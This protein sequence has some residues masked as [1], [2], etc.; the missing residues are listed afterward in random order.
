MEELNNYIKKL[1][2]L[3]EITPLIASQ[4]Q[5]YAYINHYTYEQMQLTLRYFYEVKGNDVKNSKGIGIIPFVF[6][7][8]RF[9]YEQVDKANISNRKND[10]KEVIHT[11]TIKKPV[12][13]KKTKKLKY[14]DRLE[15]ED[16]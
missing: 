14:I 16:R 13:R 9:Y 1:F 10:F 4:I 11:V 7:D 15:E 6:D 2:N 12:A 8:A 5:Q 3:P